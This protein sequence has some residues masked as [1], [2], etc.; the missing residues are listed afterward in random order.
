MNL[1]A[2]SETV[3]P[4]RCVSSNKPNQNQKIPL[5][6]DACG[7]QNLKY[8]AKINCA[9]SALYSIVISKVSMFCKKVLCAKCV[10]AK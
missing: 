4:Q 5:K 6:I 8:Y 9:L 1:S 3:K 2:V 7:L 10:L